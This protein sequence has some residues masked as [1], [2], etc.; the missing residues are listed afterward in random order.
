MNLQDEKTLNPVRFEV[1]KFD[2][3]L[4][5]IPDDD[6][7]E[8]ALQLM[9]LKFNTS[10]I[11]Y[12]ESGKEVLVRIRTNK[13]ELY[14]VNPTYSF[15]ERGNVL[16]IKIMY[17]L[18]SL[19]EDYSSHK[20]KIE[21][22][23]VDNFRDLFMNEIEQFTSLIHKRDSDK[24]PTNNFRS[25]LRRRTTGLSPELLNHVNLAVK[26]IFESNDKSKIHSVYTVYKEVNFFYK[27]TNFK[28]EK[29]VSFQTNNIGNTRVVDKRKISTNNIYNPTLSLSRSV[30][31][32][33]KEAA[34]TH[35]KATEKNAHRESLFTEENIEF[36]RDEFSEIDQEENEEINLLTPLELKL[37]YASHIKTLSKLKE[38]LSVSKSKLSAFAYLKDKVALS[39]SAEQNLMLDANPNKIIGN[40]RALTIALCLLLGMILSKIS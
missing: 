27:K 37:K 4:Y 9:N 10:A 34:S 28:A 19:S 21:I 39:A 24:K 23:I 16:D 17:L 30:N 6:I 38:E 11:M 40:N 14:A 33:I 8:E 32:I 20:F 3:Y 31:P 26:S 22:I 2:F 13:K 25:S 36:G 12:N 1:E 35:S 29:I 15:V 5:N 18:K 7:G